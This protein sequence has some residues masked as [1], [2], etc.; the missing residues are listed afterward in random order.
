MPINTSYIEAEREVVT[1]MIYDAEMA[2]FIDFIGKK[3]STT[4]E[5]KALANANNDP[6]NWRKY[7]N[8]DTHAIFQPREGNRFYLADGIPNRMAQQLWEGELKELRLTTS[9][10]EKIFAIGGKYKEYVLPREIAFFPNSSA[11]A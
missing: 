11:F 9:D 3:F 6:Q 2:D 1:Q 7:V 8:N 5:V 4:K 10:I